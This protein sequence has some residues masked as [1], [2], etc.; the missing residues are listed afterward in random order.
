MAGFDDD[1]AAADSLLTEAFGDEV[2]YLAGSSQITVA[3]EVVMRDYQVEDFEG[4]IT[5]TQS[6]DYLVDAVAL[7]VEPRPGHRIQ[8]TIGGQ[9]CTFEVVPLGKRPA[10]EWADA[11][12]RQRLIHTKQVA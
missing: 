2:T 5:T 9:V 12:H 7:G 11:Q 10:A 3:A 4:L 8:E 6:R 1:F